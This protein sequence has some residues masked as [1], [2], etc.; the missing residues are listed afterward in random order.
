[1]GKVNSVWQ[2]E[3]KSLKR[4]IESNLYPKTFLV[5]FSNA[6]KYLRILHKMC[7][8]FPYVKVSK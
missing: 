7:S 2:S 4:G 6:A 3:P 8:I 5:L 1:M